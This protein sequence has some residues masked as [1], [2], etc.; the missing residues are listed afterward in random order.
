MQAPTRKPM[1]E[2]SSRYCMHLPPAFPAILSKLGSFCS[3]AISAIMRLDQTPARARSPCPVTRGDP[4][5]PC[6]SLSPKYWPPPLHSACFIESSFHQL[7]CHECGSTKKLPGE[8]CHLAP[9]DHACSKCFRRDCQLT[10][11]ACDGPCA[12]LYHRSCM[13]EVREGH[14]LCE[15]CQVN[16]FDED[17]LFSDSNCGD[18]DPSPLA[19]SQVLEFHIEIHQ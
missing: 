3:T 14:F 7:E 8:W 17:E 2:D 16:R 12:E 11:Q 9:S 19:V 15:A 6:L 4:T 10:I 1:I 18:K 5:S 13:A